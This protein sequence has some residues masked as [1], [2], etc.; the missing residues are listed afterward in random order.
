LVD[1]QGTTLGRHEGIAGYTVG[2]R[3]GL[4]LPRRSDGEP[5]YVVDKRGDGTVVVGARADLQV[6]RLQV[7]RC[8]WVGA[9]P[10]VD[11]AVHVQ[12]RHRG[13]AVPARVES[14]DGEALV[15]EVLGPLE[16]AAR[17][18]SAVIVIP[19][20]AAGDR[21]LGGGEISEADHGRG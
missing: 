9:V 5:W 14:L 17:G 15:L 8:S 11:E 3:H 21:V 10:R 16:A 19:D 1:L 2:Q 6:R 13:Q 7:S 12:V 20:A 18:Q 4:G